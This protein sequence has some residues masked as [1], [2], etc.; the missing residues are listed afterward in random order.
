[1]TDL[2]KRLEEAEAG[3]RELTE[4]VL[5]ALGFVTKRYP[6]DSDTY[7]IVPGDERNPLPAWADRITTSLDAAL[8]LAERL[9]LDGWHPL[10]AAMLNWKAHDPRGP[11]SKTLP[12]ALCIAIL[13]ATDTGREG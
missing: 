5:L 3:S 7:W 12:L 10:Y 2:I 11:L 6:M 8:A 1:M 4:A 13:K 9:G